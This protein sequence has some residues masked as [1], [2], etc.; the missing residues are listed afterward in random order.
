M[1][2]KYEPFSYWNERK[3]PNT[4]DEQGPGRAETDYLKPFIATSSTLLELGPGL[5][6]LFRLYT[7]VRD[8][9]TLDLSTNYREQAARSAKEVGIDVE[10]HYL[11]DPLSP[12]PFDDG[13]FDLGIASFVFLHVPFENIEH[14]MSELARCCKKVAVVTP[15]HKYWPRKGSDYDPKW[16]CF[17]HNYKSIC[18][19]I[20]CLMSEETLFVQRELER[21]YGFTYHKIET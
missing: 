1:S 18:D 7:G 19:T 3:H 15:Q 10:S 8:V 11:N 9:A 6:R 13:V 17:D 16:H 20:G 5:G 12:F 21:V 2:K 4:P 14:S